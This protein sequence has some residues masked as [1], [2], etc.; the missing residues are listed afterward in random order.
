[1]TAFRELEDVQALER[2]VGVERLTSWLGSRVGLPHRNLPGMSP[3]AWSAYHIAQILELAERALVVWAEEVPCLL[4]VRRLSWDSELLGI[5]AGMLD[6]LVFPDT[7][8][9][10]A[11]TEVLVAVGRLLR[12]R[13]WDI[14]LH[15]SSTADLPAVT[16][17]GRAGFDLLAVHLDYLLPTTTVAARRAPP[18]GYAF[19]PA[20]PGDEAALAALSAENHAPFDRFRVDPLVPQERV[21]AL[22]AEW[23]RN[24]LRGYSDVA[25]VARRAGRPVGFATFGLRAGLTAATGVHCIEYQ[26]AAVDASERGRGV[27][28]ALTAAALRHLAGRGEPLV[29]AATNVLN[30]PAQ[31]VFQALGGWVHAPVLTHRLDLGRCEG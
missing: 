27:F 5:E 9:D 8:S 4:V 18:V 30:V 6:Y 21:P 2:D 3:A 28:G 19:A 17:I 13:G 11:L 29:S 25:W 24:S 7:A 10:D 15:K 14:L 12:S 20:R 23:A 26:L 22:Y 1:M 31:R 16:A